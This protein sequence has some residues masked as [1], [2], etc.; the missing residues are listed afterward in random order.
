MNNSYAGKFQ[1]HR[2]AM[3]NSRI[4]RMTVRVLNSSIEKATM[5][6]TK[7]LLPSPDD[8]FVAPIEQGMP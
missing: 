1:A 2:L 8:K 6:S 4:I 5:P 3:D 7:N